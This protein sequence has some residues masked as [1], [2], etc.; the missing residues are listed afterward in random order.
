M[1]YQAHNLQQGSPEWHAFRA[2]HFGA[3]EA[4]AMLGLSKYTSRTELLRQK[5]TGISKE[6]DANTQ[7]IFDRG[8]ATEALARPI[9]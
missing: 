4:A 6:V 2:E 5:S 1:N 9:I 3:S 8:H 7:A